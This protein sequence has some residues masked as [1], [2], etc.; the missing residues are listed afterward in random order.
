LGPSLNQ[1]SG[2]SRRQADSEFIWCMSLRGGGFQLKWSAMGP[3]GK[4]RYAMR[5]GMSVA[6]AEARACA[7]AE[8][9]S[10]QSMFVEDRGYTGLPI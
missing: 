1:C 2:N 3:V 7:S 6:Q 4:E 10:E 5:L 9:E 8:P